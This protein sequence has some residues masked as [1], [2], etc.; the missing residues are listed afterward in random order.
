VFI[1]LGQVS[2]VRGVVFQTWSGTT[3][4][5][6]AIAAD[7]SAPFVYPANA[8]GMIPRGDAQI[9]ALVFPTEPYANIF[10][11]KLVVKDMIVGDGRSATIID[12]TPGNI[13]AK[14][15]VAGNVREGS[16]REGAATK[17]QF[18]RISLDGRKRLDM[19]KALTL[20]YTIEGTATSKAD[21]RRLTGVVTI[22]KGKAGVDLTVQTL[23]DR[24]VEGAENL[25]V[26]ITP[27]L[28]Y[29]AHPTNAEATIVIRDAQ[30]R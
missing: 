23:A 16:V 24:L 6:E 8:L 22:P 30:R 29:T 5:L 14:V 3:H 21:Y 18:R 11:V 17:L 9:Q 1:P 7:F 20:V 4:Q 2:A 19:K 28:T 10:Q 13:G 12:N 25:T 26:R 15:T 27:A